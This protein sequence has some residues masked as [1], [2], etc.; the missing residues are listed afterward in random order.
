MIGIPARYAAGFRPLVFAMY[1][2]KGTEAN[3]PSGK[4]P[5]DQAASASVRNPDFF[6]LPMDGDVHPIAAP[7]ANAPKLPN[8][9]HYQLRMS[10]SN[11]IPHSN[12][13]S[14][15]HIIAAII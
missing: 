2:N 9:K 12:C 14:S 8:N 13:I 3:P 7:V 4:S 11:C 15:L 5:P 10:L 6:R 1:P